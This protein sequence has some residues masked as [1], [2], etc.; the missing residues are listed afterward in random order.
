VY[1]IL[2]KSYEDNLENP[3]AGDAG[4]ANEQTPLLRE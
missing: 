4:T 3:E 2:D 1:A